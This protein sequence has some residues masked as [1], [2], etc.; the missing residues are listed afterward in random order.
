MNNDTELIYLVN[1]L[2]THIDTIIQLL[3]VCNYII[4]YFQAIKI[5]KKNNCCENVSAARTKELFNCE[6]NSQRQNR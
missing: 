5:R 3:I 4:V 2:N 1:P 6:N